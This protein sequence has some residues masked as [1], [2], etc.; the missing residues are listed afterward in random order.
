MKPVSWCGRLKTSPSANRLSQSSFWCLLAFL[1]T[2]FISG[3][4]LPTWSELIGGKKEETGPVMV[5]PP[6]QQVQVIP[7]P[8]P[9][10]PPPKPVPAEVIAKFQ[11]LKPNQVNDGSLQ[12]LMALEKGLEA[13]N[14][15][16]LRG[17]L[18]TADG[19]KGLG[20]LTH[21]AKM[22]LRGISHTPEV[23]AYV[24]EAS[25]LEELEV[26]GGLFSMDAASHLNRLPKLR[27][28]VAERL[29]MTPASWQEFFMNHPDLETVTIP[30]SNI[31]DQVMPAVGQLSKL[32][33]LSITH[34]AITDLGLS[35]LAKLDNL[36]SL[37]IRAC[38][39]TG[40]GFRPNSGSAGFQNL[41]ELYAQETPMDRHGAN[42]VRQMKDLEILHLSGLGQMQDADFVK[43]IKPLTKLKHLSVVG[44]TQLTGQCLK[45]V[46]GHDTLEELKLGKC[47]RI[48]NSGLKYLVDCKKLKLLDLFNTSCTLEGALALQE[49]LPGLLIEGVGQQ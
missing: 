2:I 28:L 42:A 39:I 7:T 3:C 21:L 30:F 46:A 6:V 10:P 9:P 26:E 38:P 45:G 5:V 44:N 49:K 25:T 14:S 48:D 23:A 20:R 12:E 41:K 31:I 16:D 37:A 36:E 4:G 1:P 29:V 35:Q 22:D 43:I 8:A 11:S 33:R 27:V 13:I 17:S 47:P 32:R 24:A 19:L 18:V 15:L 40:I 34:T